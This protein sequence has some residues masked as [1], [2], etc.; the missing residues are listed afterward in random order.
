LLA[1]LLAP[2]HRLRGR[3]SRWGFGL[4][5][6]ALASGA[7]AGTAPARADTIGPGDPI[8]HV[9][10]IYQENHSF[11]NVLGAWCVQTGRC[12]GA[13]SAQV[14]NGTTTKTVPL[15]AAAD[16]VPPID[17][18]DTG[19]IRAM[20][21][22]KMDKWQTLSNCAAPAYNCLTQYQP[23][24][25][26]NLI[27]LANQFAVS[28]A[29]FEAN[30]MPSWGS[31][32]DLVTASMD[33]F[34]G[35]NPSPSTTGAPVGCDSN[36][37]AKWLSP[38]GQ[39]E[40]VP[41]C[42]PDPKLD[43]ATYPYGGAYRATPVQWEPTL[44]DDL[45]TKHLTW[46]LFETDSQTK[47]LPYGWA[48]C[49][50]FADCEYTIQKNNV[51]TPS[52][53]VIKAVTKGNLPNVTIVMPDLLHSQHNTYS[54]AM[55]D[56]WIGQVV[57]AIMNGPQ[58][59]ST[60]IFITYDDCGCFYDHVAPPAGDGPRVPMV[61]VSPYA[62]PGYVDS[63]PA[64]LESMLAFTEHLFALPPLG[65]TDAQSY[66]FANAFSFAA[67]PGGHRADGL[68]GRVP[69]MVTTK[70]PAAERRYVINHPPPRTDT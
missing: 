36:L 8:T 19:Q 39:L 65:R 14:F 18:T 2:S 9:V 31:H 16:V 22:G 23:S 40:W 62:K 44:M 35:D 11:D 67:A 64:T 61:I 27:S 10:I 59:Q 55:G 68:T 43:K 42:V 45:R 58:W 21:G 53:Q 54:M 25:I 7:L 66:D 46:R 50:T 33:G 4:A 49:P 12:N 20:D 5:V 6:L 51:I 17:H 41:S 29:T 32:L 69:R 48:I 24:Q 28:D 3:A 52:A 56:N 47:G 15:G 37:D 26:P 13:T 60:A 57:S 1:V 30:P 70:V 63:T 38:T 34:T